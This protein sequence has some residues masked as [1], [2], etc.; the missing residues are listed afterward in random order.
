MAVN[1]VRDS[2]RGI[3]VKPVQVLAAGANISGLPAIGAL[4]REG[5]VVGV[6]GDTPYQGEDG[7]YYANVDTG[8]EVR[9]NAIA[10]AFN[11]GDTVYITPGG[12]ISASSASNFS[13]GFATRTKNVSSG[14]LFVQLVPESS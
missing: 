2:E 1:I 11:R 4:V 5:A 9:L 10:I 12:A 6:V 14:P 3:L 8:A 7:A 13:I